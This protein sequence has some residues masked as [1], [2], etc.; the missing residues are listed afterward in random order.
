MASQQFTSAKTSRN[1]VPALHRALLRAD[2]WKPKDVN[3]DIGGGKYDLATEELRRMKVVNLVYD[4]YN[5]CDDHNS[6]V[7]NLFVRACTATVANVLNVIAEPAARIEV[8]E[9]AALV[10]VAYFTVYEGDRSELG[11]ETRDG[12][13]ENRKLATYLDEIREIMDAEVRRI[14]GVRMIVAC[15]R[16][17]PV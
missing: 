5:R 13:Q 14:G 1:Q 11:C 4:P 2:V 17:V 15:R 3:A 8:I 16:P 7:M 10:P 12:W 6:C 9:L